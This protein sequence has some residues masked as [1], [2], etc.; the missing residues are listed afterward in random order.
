MIT[1]PRVL[2][3]SCQLYSEILTQALG[4]KFRSQTQNRTKCKYSDSLFELCSRV[5]SRVR[6]RTAEHSVSCN[7]VQE[8]RR[9]CR[10]LN[11][12]HSVLDTSSILC[13]WAS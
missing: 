1:K 6:S 11:I 12:Y 7:E 13:R 8:I 2:V 10:V 9:L 5:C 3:T 4:S